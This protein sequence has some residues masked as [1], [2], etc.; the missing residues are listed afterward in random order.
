MNKHFK[1]LELDIVLKMLADEATCD[2]AKDLALSLKPVK[3]I[4]EA[5]LLLSQTEDAF[6]LL[7]R[8]GSPSFSGLRNVNNAVSRAAAGASLNPKELLDIAYTLR[9]VRSL[10]EWYGHCSNVR[11]NLDFFFE[12]I[13]VNKYLETKILTAIISEEEIADTASEEL[14]EIRGKVKF[15]ARKT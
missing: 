10:Y 11:T 14:A 6:S 7:A 9:A 2:D 15:R 1:S 5:E 13:T 12:N 8:F 4:N 3:D